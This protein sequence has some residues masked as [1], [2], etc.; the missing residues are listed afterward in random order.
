[1]EFVLLQSK[2]IAVITN[3]FD[4]EQVGKQVLIL[5]FNGASVL[6]FLRETKDVMLLSC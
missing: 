2:P 5:N 4:T 6:F 1:V 3:G